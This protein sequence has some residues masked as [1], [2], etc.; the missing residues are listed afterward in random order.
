MWSVGNG[1]SVNVAILSSKSVLFEASM[2]SLQVQVISS[3][4]CYV[5]IYSIR[6]LFSLFLLELLNDIIDWLVGLIICNN[7][8]K[9][10]AYS[11][12][13]LWNIRLLN[14]FVLRSNDNHSL[15]SRKIIAGLVALYYTQSQS[16]D[17]CL[18]APTVINSA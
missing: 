17:R 18:D 9:W 12:M 14:Q 4:C 6:I 3:T 1:S 7:C 10:Q 8:V 13:C 16:S 5:K 15:E 2:N 11:C